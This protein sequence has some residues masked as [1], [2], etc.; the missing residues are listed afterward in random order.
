MTTDLTIAVLTYNRSDYLIEMLESIQKQTYKNFIVK[1]L[2]NASTDNTSDAIKPFLKDARFQY[3]QHKENIGGGGNYNYALSNCDTPYLLITHDDDIMRSTFLEA[4]INTI[5]NNANTIMVSTKAELIDENRFFIENNDTSIETTD[6][7]TVFKTFE[8]IENYIIDLTHPVCPTIML[9]M[10]IINE[11]K[12][13]VTD[14]RC[15]SCDTIFF[16]ELNLLPYDIVFINEKLYEY[17]VHSKQDSTNWT[18]MIPLLRNTVYK[19]LKK[20]NKSLT[21]KWLLFVAKHSIA[22]LNSNTYKP[23]EKKQIK[24]LIVLDKKV[25]I[26]MRWYVY[27]YFHNTVLVSVLDYIIRFPF[28]VKNKIFREISKLLKGRFL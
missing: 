13:Q 25:D 23:H 17:R 22:G 24:D 18:Y 3:V 28:R 19:L 1:I 11:H 4:E 12:L 9:N 26:K 10:N 27:K 5:K 6:Y 20:T 16:F 21:K 2:D 7:T 15:I 14:S 8:L